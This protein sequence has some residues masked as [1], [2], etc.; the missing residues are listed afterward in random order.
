MPRTSRHIQK[1]HKLRQVFQLPL[2]RIHVPC[3]HVSYQNCQKIANKL[4]FPAPKTCSYAGKS[5]QFLATHCC[6]IIAVITCGHDDDASSSLK[7]SIVSE[8]L[9]NYYVIRNN[10]FLRVTVYMFS[11]REYAL[12]LLIV[13]KQNTRD[14]C[15]V[16][17]RNCSA[18]HFVSYRGI[19]CTFARCTSF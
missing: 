10:Y 1:Y 17:G 15:T 16:S 8:H 12:Y 2:D 4:K 11:E 3:C 9:S 6:D 5:F 19:V 18:H 14:W 13:N 7:L